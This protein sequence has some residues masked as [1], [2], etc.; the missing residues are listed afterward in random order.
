MLPIRYTEISD[1]ASIEEVT[2]LLEELD[3]EM[4]K[5]AFIRAR[6]AHMSAHEDKEQTSVKAAFHKFD[7]DNSGHMDAEEFGLLA[8]EL[9]TEPPLR[10]DELQEGL[11]QVCQHLACVVGSAV[12]KPTLVFSWMK[13]ERGI[14]LLRSFGNGGVLNESKQQPVLHSRQTFHEGSS[15]P[16]TV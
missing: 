1:D 14:F 2:D 11:K 15:D 13:M 9:G 3:R 8:V 10:P 5:A 12:F 16:G 4:A 6:I 7:A